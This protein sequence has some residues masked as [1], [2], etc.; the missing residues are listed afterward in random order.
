MGVILLPRTIVPRLL[1]FTGILLLLSVGA[2]FYLVRALEGRIRSQVDLTARL[3]SA[4]LTLPGNQEIPASLIDDVLSRLDFPIV[5]TDPAGKPQAWRNIPGLPDEPVAVPFDSL[6]PGDQKKVLSIVETAHQAGLEVPLSYEGFELGRLFFTPPPLLRL[7]RTLPWILLVVGLL[8]L[9]GMIWSAHTLSEAYARELW[10]LFAKGLAHQMGTPLSSLFGWVEH[11]KASPEELP[12]ILNDMEQD[13]EDLRDISLRFSRI[14]QPPTFQIFDLSEALQRWGYRWKRRWL[15]E[16]DLVLDL[17]PARVRGD[18]ILLRWAVE[19]LVKNAM[20]ATQNGGSIRVIVDELPTRHV[21]LRVVDQGTGVP[22]DVRRHLFSMRVS[23][24]PRGWGMG[25]WVVKKIVEEWH[26]G[27]VRL[28]TTR[29]G[30]T[31]FE[32]LLPGT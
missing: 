30:H 13:L 7:A 23:T 6:P 29:P 3:Y 22:E 28:V 17:H 20:E 14:G 27:Q 32:I 10:A 25:L 5:I 9:V 2:A 12:D 26:G 19:N 15:R 21:R 31:E 4:L 24:K 8:S 16:V 18:E 11:L 1:V